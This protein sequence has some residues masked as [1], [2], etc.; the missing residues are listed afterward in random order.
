MKTRKDLP[1]TYDEGYILTAKAQT[2]MIEISFI[3]DCVLEQIRMPMVT[4][5]LGGDGIIRCF[6]TC[7]GAC[8]LAYIEEGLLTEEFCLEHKDILDEKTGIKESVCLSIMEISDLSYDFKYMV[9][10]YM[11]VLGHMLCMIP[12]KDDICG[13]KRYFEPAIY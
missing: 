12:K 7:L 5:M 6:Q 11:T 9:S 1:T 8:I 4:D 3:N 13:N 2:V 10:Q